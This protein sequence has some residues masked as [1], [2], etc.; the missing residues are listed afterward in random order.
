M[1]IGEQRVVE[2]IY[3]APVEAERIHEFLEHW[4][5]LLVEALTQ[6][7]PDHF[8]REYVQKHM[9]RALSMFDKLEPQHSG[10]EIWHGSPYPTLLCNDAGNIVWLNE[11]ARQL[12]RVQAQDHITNLP[13][14][15]ASMQAL[16]AGIREVAGADRADQYEVVKLVTPSGETTCFAGLRRAEG[17]GAKL[18]TDVIVSA[19]Q[20]V[21]PDSLGRILRDTLGFTVKECEVV[22]SLVVGMSVADIANARS[23][24]INTVRAQIR[25]IYEKTGIANQSDLFR[26][27]MSVT[28]LNLARPLFERA[29]QIDDVVGNYPLAH[30]RHVVR[31]GDAGHKLDYADFGDPQGFPVVLLHDEYYGYFCTAEFERAARQRSLRIIAPARPGFGFTEAADT[32]QSYLEQVM[33]HLHELLNLLDVSE[34]SI[35]AKRTGLRYAV[36]AAEDYADRVRSVVAVAPA[37]PVLVANQYLS[38]PRMARMISMAAFN[39]SVLLELVCR[40]G[41]KYYKSH[42]A[43]RFAH[44]LNKGHPEDLETLKDEHIWPAMLAGLNFSASSKH[45]G[46]MAEVNYDQR[47]LWHQMRDMKLPVTCVI[48]T[49]DQNGRVSRA[50]ALQ[51]AGARLNVQMVPGAAGLVFH[52]HPQDVLAGL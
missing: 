40:T 44:L 52:T 14:D 24:S 17:D 10:G 48:G 28:G 6:N 15:A 4:D 5:S 25:S 47:V 51:E 49:Q 22:Q 30:Q 31:I 8:Q 3:A 21:W 23:R 13:F 38:M 16:T 41:F 32:A 1:S 43:K 45:Q 42:G 33:L 18:S 29:P 20:L 26:L 34:F 46:Y 37:L 11:P 35:L 9:R 2:E 7:K 50:Q 12:W 19:N 27:A 39:N 36:R